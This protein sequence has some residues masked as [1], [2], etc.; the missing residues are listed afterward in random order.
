MKEKKRKGRNR[1]VQVMTGLKEGPKKGG[2]EGRK[3]PTH[4]ESNREKYEKETI[5]KEK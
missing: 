2:K 3:T 1:E 4:E 5:D